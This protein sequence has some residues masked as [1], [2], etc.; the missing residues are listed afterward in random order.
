VSRARALAL[1]LATAAL[2]AACGPA[3]T[4]TPGPIDSGSLGAPASIV[5]SA[6]GGPP[7]S[8]VA[9]VLTG[10]DSTGLTQVTGFTLRTNDG[11]T[12]EFK[13]GNLEN[14]NQF[15]PGHLAEHLATSSPV[16]VYFRPQGAD[17]VVYRLE[18][19]PAP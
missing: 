15:P 1:V 4:P 3:A 2:V 17:L 12:I 9:G 14:G 6:A 7:V 10:I 11:R 18:D 19:A 5:P 13:L 8:P 16:L